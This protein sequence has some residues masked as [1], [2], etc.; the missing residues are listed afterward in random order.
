MCIIRGIRNII[1]PG[2]QYFEFGVPREGSDDPVSR[3]GTV[4]P[5]MYVKGIREIGY[6][7]SME[8]VGRLHDPRGVTGMLAV[9]AA[10]SVGD[11]VVVAVFGRGK[12]S[13]VLWHLLVALYFGA[14]A[15]L[16]SSIGSEMSGLYRIHDYIV[17]LD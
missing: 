3:E 16:R 4:S 11:A 12:Y 9:G 15:Y 10:M 2:N 13:M 5:L 6:G 14:M 1:T 17:Y 7:V 8:V